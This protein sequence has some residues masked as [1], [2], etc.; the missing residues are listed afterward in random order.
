M[1][2]IKDK[3]VVYDE[4]DVPARNP[5]SRPIPAPGIGHRI[6]EVARLLGTRTSAYTVMGISSAALQRYIKEENEPPFGPL[7]RLCVA[8]GARMDWLATGE[9]D[10]RVGASEAAPDKT[11]QSARPDAD[12]IRGAAEVMERALDQAHA[13]TDAS[14]RAELLLAIYDM[15][16]SGLALEA[17][18]RAVAGMLRA[19][20]RSTGVRQEQ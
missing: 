4:S 14:G 10:M 5:T 15:L 1:V 2:T 6:G 11:A 8:A 17:A 20:A 16:Q 13:T 3:S 9:G 7:A 12:L 18:G 19:T